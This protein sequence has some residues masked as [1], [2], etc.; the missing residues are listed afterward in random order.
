MPEMGK[1]LNNT[2]TVVFFQRLTQ[3]A[4]GV[5]LSTCAQCSQIRTLSSLNKKQVIPSPASQHAITQQVRLEKI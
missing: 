5:A 3:T 1:A 4:E 2:V